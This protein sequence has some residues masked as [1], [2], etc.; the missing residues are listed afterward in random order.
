VSSFLLDA[1]LS[2]KTA[3]FLARRFGFDVLILRG[4]RQHRLTDH[5]VIELAR[6][7]GRVIITLDRDYAEYYFRTTHPAVGII[8]LDL[9]NSHRF[10]PEINRVL[11][12]FFATSGADLNLTHALVILSEQTARIMR[13]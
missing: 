8:Y 6:S 1:N 9:P 7:Q 12:R 10:I 4:E 13:Q 2:P 11:E 3:R 5:E